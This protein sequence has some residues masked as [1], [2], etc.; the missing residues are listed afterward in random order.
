MCPAPG[1]ASATRRL[2]EVAGPGAGPAVRPAGPRHRRCQGR[3]RPWTGGTSPAITA[4]EF[5][6]CPE[7]A[8][9]P[10]GV[11]LLQ[12]TRHPARPGHRLQRDTRLRG[13]KTL[14]VVTSAESG[15]G[16]AGAGGLPGRGA[17]TTLAESV[18]IDGCGQVCP[19]CTSPLP[20]WAYD[21]EPPF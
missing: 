6:T 8:V 13:A 4:A 17:L 15:T 7:R 3:A 20:E 1:P 19:R 21:L 18:Y 14:S 11:G 10:P 9:P 2:T 16:R 5:G 12:V